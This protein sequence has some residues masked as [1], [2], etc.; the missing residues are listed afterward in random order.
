MLFNVLF[1]LI[2]ATS[3]GITRVADQS[4]LTCSHDDYKCAHSAQCIELSRVCDGVNDCDDGSDEAC[5]ILGGSSPHESDLV[6]NRDKRQSNC[7]RDQWQCRDGSCISFDGK[8]DGM[9]DCPDRS[10]ETHALCRKMPC[11]ANWFRCTYGACVDGT[12]PCNGVTECADNSDEL[13]PR[14]RNETMEVKGRFRCK[15]SSWISASDHC[16]G[17]PDCPDGSDETVAACADKSCPSYLFQCAYGACVD[18]GADCNG[19][20]ECADGSDESDELCNRMLTPGTNTNTGTTTGTTS[21]PPPPG[22]CVLPPYPDHGTYEISNVPS[23]RPG[24]SFQS[25]VMT[26]SCQRGYGLVDPGVDNNGTLQVY[27][28][29]GVWYTNMPKCV[30]F[31]KLD[32]DPSVRYICQHNTP[33]K[34]YIAPGAT[35]NPVCNSPN[36]YSSEVL[37]YM[38]CIAGSFDYVAICK[39]ECGRVTPEGEQLVVGGKLAKRGELPWHVGIYRKTTNPYMQI[40]GG[41]LV[42]NK[43]VISAAHCFWNDV[44]KALPAS[45]FAV[46]IGKLYRPWN[47]DRDVD[48]QKSD[49]QEIRLPPLFQGSAANFQEDI[50]VLVLVT[51]FVYMTYVRPVCLNFDTNFDRRQLQQGKNGK[52]AGWGLTAAN[53]NASQVLRVVDMPYINVDTCINTLP[54]AFREYITGDKFCA[55]YTNGTALCKGDSGGGLAFADTELGIERYYL[56]GV[57]STAP[58]NENKCN[59]DTYTTFTKITKH[60]DFIKEF[61]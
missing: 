3:P 32:P 29:N 40:C 28:V 34:N 47:N 15:D 59:V 43:V 49:V 55:G 13:L 58:S 54:P 38:K 26:V 17:N 8:C 22:A 39:A 53:G 42:S 60:E 12:A 44:S 7:R 31:C 11:Q 19:K 45:A 61:L 10:D 51:P 25:F 9:V 41:S 4:Q 24:Q 52:V 18:R 16:D 2:L 35:V 50:A 21:A 33:C 57:V 27:C 14:C 20:R 1:L 30:R 48:A 46:A 36:Y 23:A 6:L 56:R 37:K 5:S